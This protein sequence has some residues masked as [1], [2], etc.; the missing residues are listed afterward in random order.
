MQYAKSEDFSGGTA[1]KK[2]KKKTKENKR[3]T[4]KS[5]SYQVV[6]KRAKPKATKQISF[7]CSF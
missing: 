2:K 7:Q 4:Q 5:Q 6:I 3:K 1:K